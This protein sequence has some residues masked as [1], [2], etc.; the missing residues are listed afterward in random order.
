[1]A[2]SIRRTPWV[3]AGA[4]WRAAPTSIRQYGAASK[5]PCLRAGPMFRI[6]LPPAVSPSRTC[7]SG[8]RPNVRG[9]AAARP[10]YFALCVNQHPNPTL[11]ERSCV[12]KRGPDPPGQ[13]LATVGLGPRQANRRDQ[14]PAGIAAVIAGVPRTRIVLQLSA[15]LIPGATRPRSR[16]PTPRAADQLAVR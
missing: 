9:G 16:S 3:P 11:S 14:K 2:G 4:N 7:M 10:S 6:H 1:M 8:G 13:L 12:A 15:T 5:P